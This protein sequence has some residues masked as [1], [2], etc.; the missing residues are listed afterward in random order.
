MYGS[1]P[2]KY[3]SLINPLVKK[4]A[5]LLYFILARGM[6]LIIEL[7]FCS[8]FFLSVFLISFGIDC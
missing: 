1:I 7:Y 6:Q 3:L 8:F 2:S 4:F 5:G